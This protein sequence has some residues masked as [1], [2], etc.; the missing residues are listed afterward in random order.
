MIFDIKTLKS[1]QETLL[2]KEKKIALFFMLTGIIAVCCIVYFLTLGDFSIFLIGSCLLLILP[3]LL[4]SKLKEIQKYKAMLDWEVDSVEMKERIDNKQEIFKIYEE[5]FNLF[6]YYYNEDWNRDNPF[7]NIIELGR[8]FIFI[9]SKNPKIP[10]DLKT[11]ISDIQIPEETKTRLKNELGKYW[12]HVSQFPLG[13]F[14]MLM[15]D[16]KSYHQGSSENGTR[17]PS[18]FLEWMIKFPK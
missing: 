2:K 14:L 11:I 13:K 18:E 17:S 3:S 7:I 4:L 6:Y 15:A 10:Y 9:E 16:L 1:K 8:S 5:Y 12:E